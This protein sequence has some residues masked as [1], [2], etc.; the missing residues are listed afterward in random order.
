MH[1]SLL[2][3]LSQHS[4]LSLLLDTT[5]FLAACL[6]AARRPC[7]ME[8]PHLKTQAFSKPKQALAT[9]YVSDLHRGR[10]ASIQLHTENLKASLKSVLPDGLPDAVAGPIS[11]IERTTQVLYIL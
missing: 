6:C 4:T 10:H 7:A 5:G 3:S 1:I 8:T 9:A 11:S 2:R